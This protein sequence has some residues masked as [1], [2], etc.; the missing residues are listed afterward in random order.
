[1]TRITSFALLILIFF[2]C[3]EKNTP[4][5]DL[6]ITDVGFFNGDKDM[7]TMHL[8][9]NA[10]TIAAISKEPLQAD[11]LIDGKGKYIIP[12]LVN[13]HVHVSNLD[14]LKEGYNYGILAYLNMHTSLEDRED[15]WKKMSKDSI[16][17]PLLYGSGHAAT[18]PGGHPNQFSPDMETINDSISIEQWVDNRIAKGVDYIKIVRDNHPWLNYPPIPTLSFEQIG[19]IINYAKSKGYKTV[20]HSITM[21]DILEIVKFKP[22]GF[23]HMMERTNELPISD[24][25]YKTLAE[26]GA[27]IV[28]NAVYT[29]KSKEELPPFMKEWLNEHVFSTEQAAN[30]IKKLHEFGIPIIAGT[31]AQTGLVNFG[32]DYY[33]ELEMYK[34]AGLS[35]LEIL[36]TATGNAA[37]GFDLP[38]GE[39]KIGSKANMV[40]LNDNPLKDIENLKKV[41]QVWKNG[42]SKKIKKK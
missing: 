1:M 20:V 32:S 24:D 33:L 11:S 28:P 30:S 2:S 17:Y 27:F 7:G 26:S 19:Q 14:E 41:E 22:D 8:A 21:G 37:K 12:G 25:D 42:K 6:V 4:Q 23:V 13:A 3:S 39:L 29:L 36:K 38:I 18:V 40:M 5:Y 10:D 35:N 9:I 31:D 16:G 15:Q 34:R